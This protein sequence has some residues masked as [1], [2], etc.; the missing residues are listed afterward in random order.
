MKKLKN[1]LL[2]L[3]VGAVSF[4]A[5]SCK[6]N[7]D[8]N[9]PTITATAEKTTLSPDEST[10]ISII[11]NA[12]EGSKIKT[13]K[14]DEVTPG[15]STP[16]NLLSE[17][18]NSATYSKV[19]K[20]TVPKN[21]TGTKNIVVT[22]TDDK[23]RTTT[24]S[25][26]ITIVSSGP[27]DNCGTVSLGN[28]D[29]GQDGSFY[30]TSDCKVYKS[31]EAATNANEIDFVHFYGAQNKASLASPNDQSLR[32]F[33]RKFK[34]FNDQNIKRTTNF[35]KAAAGFDFAGA[36][37]STVKAAFDASTGNSLTLVPDLATGDMI[38]FQ[39]QDGRYGVIK[40]TNITG[41]ANT[42][43]NLTAEIKTQK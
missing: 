33:D 15:T 9:D 13:V 6:K 11:V 1:Y 17:S 2:L 12:D 10:N 7:E 19:Y 3:A 32:S 34:A 37:A 26:T 43:G 30:A 28:A 23:D 41:D 20:Y 24:K 25:I 14:V 5:V 29:N 4:G 8:G 27:L 40:I 35:K 18:P 21:A 16:S 38:L 39:T 36:T 22:A 42:S 31:A